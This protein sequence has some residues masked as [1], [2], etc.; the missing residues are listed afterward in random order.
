MS[1]IDRI[2][3]HTKKVYLANYRSKKNGSSDSLDDILKENEP[4]IIEVRVWN[5]TVANL[6]LMAFGTASPEILLSIVEVVAHHFESGKLGPATI[7]GSAAFNLLI[8]TSV[9]M[10][11]L[12]AGATKR[13]HRLKVFIVTG[14][15]SLFAYVWLLI[16]LRYVTPN[17]IE[18]W[19]ASI[20]FILFPILIIFAY[21][22]DRDYFG[23]L[24][25]K[26]T[27]RQMELDY[28]DNGLDKKT[29]QK[30]NLYRE[31][32]QIDKENLIHFIKQTKKFPN[33]KDEE[34]AVLAA[35]KL[36]DATSH[37]SNWYRINSVRTFAGSRRGKPVLD[38][39]L[40][41][42]YD[43]LKNH[44]D[45]LKLEDIPPQ[46][47]T[48]ET[49]CSV[50]EF[51]SPNI[52]V[53]ENV[54]Q[55][56]VSVCRYG[57]LQSEVKVKIDSVDGSAKQGEDYVPVREILTFSPYESEKKV[58]VKIID[59]N[60]WEPDEEF[61]LRLTL[62]GK[63]NN[64]VKLGQFPIMEVTIMDDDEPGIIKFEKRG[65]VVKESTGCIKVP[66][67]RVRGADGDVS[68]KWKT[69]DKSAIA[70]RDYIGGE[71]ILTFRHNETKQELT[72]TIIDD[73]NPEKDEYFEIVLYDPTNG[74]KIGNINRVLVTISN[75][76]DFNTVAHRLMALTGANLD[77]MRV[78]TETWAEQFKEAMSV[79]GGDIEHAQF[80]DYVLHFFSF[81]WKVLFAF[82]PPV[83]IFEGWLCFFVSLCMI[84]IMTIIIGDLAT[85]FGCLIDLDDTITAITLVALGTTLPD[86]LGAG[87]VTRN[88]EH[89]DG[90]LIHISGSIA[91][92]VL[93]GVGVPWF[94]AALYHFKKGSEFIVESTGLEFSVLLFAI[95]VIIAALILTVRRHTPQCGRAELGGP[96]KTRYL[97][98]GIFVTLWLLY[99]LFIFLQITNVINPF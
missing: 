74:A 21:A 92:N 48:G 53:R 93:I 16:I 7:V 13:V 46:L 31:D 1:A 55:F 51:H 86:I 68:V 65:M 24:K 45:G 27:K 75:D 6:I 25:S 39:K 35:T 73:L 28:M 81:F 89:A 79:K 66:V 90:A 34:I 9:C 32:G 97:T 67:V 91:V 78:H 76:D 50:I 22:T 57:N 42:I 77:A 80:W 11:A 26:E 43:I 18:L 41:Q 63:Y 44:P 99:L 95:A 5:D 36:L 3:S 49:N 64:K 47:D 20:T 40:K 19:E 83:A 38:A 88:E 4:E 94:V 72:F 30:K 84:G 85:I 62:V 17:V 29:S 96:M 8:I 59:D 69:V 58:P 15:F 10:L 52:S 33:L 71:G 98:V 54:G 61:F 82:I 70:G 2:T 87:M 37:S 56:F 23:L 60:K 12:P 14:F